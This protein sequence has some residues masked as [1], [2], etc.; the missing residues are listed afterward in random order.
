MDGTVHTTVATTVIR[1]ERHL[2][3]PIGE[4]LTALTQPDQLEQWL[5]SPAEIW[6]A[7][8]FPDTGPNRVGSGTGGELCRNGGEN[9]VRSIVTRR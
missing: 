4:V 3:H 1:F 7:P 5:A 2:S 8:W 6:S 9:L